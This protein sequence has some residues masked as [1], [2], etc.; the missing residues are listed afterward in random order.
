MKTLI[1]VNRSAGTSRNTVTPE[2]LATLFRRRGAEAQA[3][4]IDAGSA[5]ELLKPS[6]LSRMD[7]VVAA[8]GDG[9]LSGLAGRLVNTR[10]PL[11][12]LPVG[13]LNHFAKDLRI[14][15]DLEQAIEC[16]LKR[17]I[18]RVD[19]GEVNGHIF[20]N[21]SSIGAYPH[22]VEH[23]DH[24]QRHLG[25]GKWLAMLVAT[26]RML[27]RYPLLKARLLIDHRTLTRTT[28]FIFIGNN[29]YAMDLLSIG[30]RT[31]L[32]EGIL[33]VYTAHCTN[34]WGLV[35]LAGH[36][37]LNRLD[38]AA[39]FDALLGTHLEVELRGTDRAQVAL[40][41]EL[42]LMRLPLLYRSR[43]AALRVITP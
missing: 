29:R 8:G 25:R 43:P 10:I 35:R 2:E 24:Q 27:S 15:L 11:G 30:A 16:V 37:L 41:G 33:S 40:D 13:T 14:P 3:H 6:V 22:M 1:L 42:R 12:V 5:G 23:R 34:R 18:S 36:A 28:P 26:G 4:W 19:V 31:S 7:A 39:D 20:I 9:T 21:N 32:E 38:Q 17:N